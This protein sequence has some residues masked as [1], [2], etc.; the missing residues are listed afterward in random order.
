MADVFLSYGR[1]ETARAEQVAKCLEAA[2]LDVFWDN[3][4]PPGTT[5]ADY[6]ESKLTQCKALIVLWS[7]HSTKS[8]WVREEARMGRDKGVLIPVMIDGSQPPFGFGE[9]QAAN[10]A[11]WNGEADHP[12]WRRF[13]D[14]VMNITKAE[15][16]PAPP[17]QAQ[18]TPQPRTVQPP[19]QQQQAW[20]TPPA[21]A[22][23]DKKSIPVW[24]WIGGGMV[25]TVAVLAVVGTMMNN[26]QQQQAYSV[27][28]PA[29]TQQVQQP[30]QTGDQNPQQIIVAQLQQAQGALAQQGFQQVGQPFSGGLQPGEAWNVQAQMNAG[31]EYQIVGVCDR[32]CS[33]LDIRLYDSTGNLIVEDTTT[34]SQPNVGVLPG[35]N[36]TFTI[37]VHMYACTVAPC[38]YAV[39]LYGRPRQ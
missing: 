2:G 31:Y 17:P 1:A 8:Q 39:A 10:L 18:P 23:A 3:E 28:P 6:I 36:D 38:Y 5:W 12:N 16:R 35:S 22:A 24:V 27:P 7:E 30:P 15:P 32:D 29:Q 19:Q 33:D 21:P 4:I 34:T 20:S 25:A 26:S 14:A 11:S 13:V 9:V 37:Q